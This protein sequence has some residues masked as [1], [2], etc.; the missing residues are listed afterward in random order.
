MCTITPVAFSTRRSAGRRA[1]A[2]SLAE[3][4]R[5][6]A[7]IDAGA[8]LARAP[9]R[10][11][12][13]QRRPRAGS[14]ARARELVD[15]G[16]IAQLHA[17]RLRRES[18]GPPQSLLHCRGE[19]RGSFS[20]ACVA[21][22]RRRRGRRARAA[23]PRRREAGRPRAR[24][25]RRREEPRRRSTSA[26]RRGRSGRS[27][28]APAGAPTTCRRG[29]L[30]AID[31]HATA[32]RA[33]AAGSPVVARSSPQR[34]DVAP[35]VAPR[36]RR[37]QRA[38]RRSRAPN[39]APVSATVV[40]CTAR[41]S[42]TTPARVGLR[43]RPGGA[44]PS[45]RPR[46]R[47]VVDAPLHPAA[48][49]RSRDAAARALPPTAR[50]AARPAGRDRLP[51]RPARRAHAGA[52]RARAAHQARRHRFAVT[53]DGERARAASSVRGSARWIVRAHNA[54]FVVAGERVRIVPSRPAATST[55]SSSPLP[56][57]RRRTATTSRT[58]S[59]APR[60][61]DLTTAKAKALGIRQKLVSYTTQM[62]ESSS[63]RIH[64]VHLMA[65]FIDGTVIEPGEVFSF[66]DVVG[67]AH[68][69]ARVPRGAGDHRLARAAVDRRRRLPD[70]D[71]A[72][73][74]RVRAR[75]AD[76]RAHEPQPLPR[77]LS[78]RPRRD[79]VVGR[80][81]LPVPERPEAR[82]PDQD[83][84]HRRDADVH[85]LRHARAPPRRLAHRPA[86]ELDG[87]VDELRGRPERAARLG[88]G[89]RRAPASRASTSRSTARCTTATASC[90]AATRFKSH[91]IPDSPTT[92][93]GP[94]KTPPGPYIVIC[95]STI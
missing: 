26:L 30:V 12:S 21:R 39:R 92:V 23:V 35:V 33:L 16:Q 1:A 55:R 14:S 15:R 65:D 18:V 59:S 24:D 54:Q 62:G 37:G 42:S 53:F 11:R 43:A 68:G 71:D 22:G 48:R 66:N 44:A 77:A 5:E 86:G 36:R 3:P 34:V 29:W 63:N 8:D 60:D 38:A 69:R 85:V 20:S 9:G 56:S 78:D 13:A 75:A 87:P 47:R 72:L 93:Y 94:G 89:R 67:A 91:Y 95:R 51:R 83:V 28:S 25:R 52:A 10:S 90:C 7:R 88:Q 74:R 61:P 64:N 58:S 73:Q 17:G 50:T 79:R 81:R 84:V 76:S 49:R 27:R 40:R 41:R 19:A 4:R 70:G 6:V 82:A 45:A 46:R 31:T 32:T 57:R 80:A 2:S